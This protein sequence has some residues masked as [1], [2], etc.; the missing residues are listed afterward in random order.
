VLCSRQAGSQALALS[1]MRPLGVRRV[2]PRP[3][4][5]EEI[6]TAID[7]IVAPAVAPQR[8]SAS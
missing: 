3:C 4:R 1:A 5:F 2:L 8:R 7:E 6:A